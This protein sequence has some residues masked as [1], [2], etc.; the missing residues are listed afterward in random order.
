[1]STYQ[2][3]ASRD[4]ESITKAVVP[5]FNVRC[6]MAILLAIDAPYVGLGAVAFY[7]AHGLA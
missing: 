3:V 5:Q 7:C 4:D 6:A 2:L 1:M